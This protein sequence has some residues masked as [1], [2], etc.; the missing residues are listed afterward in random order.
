MVRNLFGLTFVGGVALIF[1]WLAS[2]AGKGVQ[3]I[4][5]YFVGIQLVPIGIL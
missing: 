5:A 1:L 2:S 4:A 3:Q